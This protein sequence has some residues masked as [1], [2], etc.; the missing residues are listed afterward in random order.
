MERRCGT[1]LLYLVTRYQTLMRTRPANGAQQKIFHGYTY[2]HSRILWFLSRLT[3]AVVKPWASS[4]M[5]AHSSTLRLIYRDNA[6][7]FSQI[8]LHSPLFAPASSTRTTSFQAA[9]LG[10]ERIESMLPLRWTLWRTFARVY[11]ER[12]AVIKRSTRW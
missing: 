12:S 7:P 1:T 10:R 2:V 6:R 11:G 9:F 8:S 4:L 5:V 3:N